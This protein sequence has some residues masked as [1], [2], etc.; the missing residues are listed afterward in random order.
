MANNQPRFS[1][2]IKSDSYQRLINDTLGDKEIARKFVADISSVVSN[3][4]QL[5]NCDAGSILAAGLT[6]QSL[7]LP[8]SQTLGFAYIVPYGI[9][10][11]FQI[12]KNGLVQL[13]LRTGQYEKLGVRPVHEGELIDQDEFG[14][15]V[16]KFSHEFDDKPVIG[17]MAYL[18]LVN[19]FAKKIYWTV[20]QCEKHGAKY[21]KSY[22]SAS[23]TNLWKNEF[24]D[25]AQKTVLK[26]LIS[27]WGIMSTELQMAIQRDQSVIREDGTL[28][29]VDRT[30]EKVEERKT[31]VSNSILPAAEDIEVVEI[32]NIETGKNAIK[33]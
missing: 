25:M 5:A 27:K 23:S 33:V 8:L 14:E 29:Y 20:A 28:D 15:D 16:F 2:A 6:A 24:D 30:E 12:G 11:Q 22:H 3:N 26:Q 1:I 21:S 32:S 18:R 17:Y 10:A 7:N 19:G 31:T 9:K 13:A 4:Y